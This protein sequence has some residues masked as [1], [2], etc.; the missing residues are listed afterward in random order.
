[1]VSLLE[2][3]STSSIVP[4]PTICKADSDVGTLSL[5][6]EVSYDTELGLDIQ[7][8]SLVRQLSDLS[9]RKVAL[10]SNALSLH[11][12]THTQSHTPVGEYGS[13]YRTDEQVHG[14]KGTYSSTGWQDD[15]ST[16]TV[17]CD[18]SKLVYTHT[19]PHTSSVS[20]R[21]N[22]GNPGNPGTDPLYETMKS[23]GRKR[24]M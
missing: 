5:V 21:V 22:P 18:S 10:K 23:E 3:G 11:P 19:H 9:D 16:S 8:R 7:I 20:I 2:T 13:E 14:R 17:E 1:M 15:P 12:H 4:P 6:S 24:L